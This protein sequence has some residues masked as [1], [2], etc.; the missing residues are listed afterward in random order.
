VEVLE[1]AVRGL[2]HRPL[3]LGNPHALLVTLGK[4]ELP[5]LDVAR[6]DFRLDAE[7]RPRFLEMN[8]LPTFAP[9]GSFGILAEIEGRALADLLAEVI[10]GGLERLGLG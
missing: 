4:G 10:A 9:D 1:Q 7:D 6:A 5:G 3:R 2:G 8:P